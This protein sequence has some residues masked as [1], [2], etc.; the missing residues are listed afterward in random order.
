MR[1]TCSRTSEEFR[2][3]QG[4]EPAAVRS[5]QLLESTGP[6]VVPPSGVPG[7]AT[8]QPPVPATAPITGASAPLQAANA[9]AAQGGGSRKE[10]VTNYEVD[11][12]VRVTRSATGVVRRL[13]AAVVVNHQADAKGAAQAL[14]PAQMEQINALVREAIG[15]SKER[16]DSVN[17]VNAAFRAAP[18]AAVPALPLWRQPEVLGMVR[19]LAPWVALPIVALAIIF[20]MVRPALRA[21]RATPVDGDATVHDAVPLPT[22]GAGPS[23][24]VN[25]P[26]ASRGLPGAAPGVPLLPTA[27]S[28]AQH[29]RNAQLESIRHLARA[30]PATVANVV[31]NWVSPSN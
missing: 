5:A 11:K 21:S 26:D 27:E 23:V 18:V 31:R 14:S 8:N 6:G 17:V 15:Y 20:G 2:P 3:N 13:N 4:Q 16:G 28:A 22:P 10:Q 19:T 12:T 29:T 25:L 24:S 9:G 30:N 7:A 1:A